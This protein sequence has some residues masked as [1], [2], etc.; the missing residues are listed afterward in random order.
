MP[1]GQTAHTQHTIHYGT[2]S[3]ALTSHVLQPNTVHQP[4]CSN[5]YG[6]SQLHTTALLSPL[7][8]TQGIL[9]SVSFSLPLSLF[10]SHSLAL[11]VLFFFSLS[12]CLSN[13]VKAAEMEKSAADCR[14]YQRAVDKLKDVEVSATISSSHR[15]VCS[16]A[17][18]HLLPFPSTSCI[19]CQYVYKLRKHR[20]SGC[21]A[22][23]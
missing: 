10:V 14:R 21:D 5:N 23:S 2:L 4:R 18:F 11:S 19:F 1:R 15:I 13:R 9:C 7:L 3:N 12:L 22:A 17:T 6:R 8:F 16:T 20:R